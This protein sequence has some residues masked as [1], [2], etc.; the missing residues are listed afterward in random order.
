MSLQ[1]GP[2]LNSRIQLLLIVFFLL[3]CKANLFYS[4]FFEKLLSVGSSVTTGVKWGIQSWA[5]ALGVTTMQQIIIVILSKN[6]DQHT[7]KGALFLEK[8]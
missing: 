3:F 2:L 5:Q 8:C 6:L 4:V 1:I 7:P